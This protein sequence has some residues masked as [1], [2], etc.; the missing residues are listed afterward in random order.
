[1][2]SGGSDVRTT[3]CFDKYNFACVNTNVKDADVITAFAVYILL[4][5]LLLASF[6]L[7]RHNNTHIL[8]E[9]LFE[10]AERGWKRA[11]A[12]AKT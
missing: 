8:W 7:L 1:M 9:V 12:F 6:G 2:S 11:A 4:A 3:T 10:F 5:F